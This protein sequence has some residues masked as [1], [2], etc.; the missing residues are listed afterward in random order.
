MLL[1]YTSIFDFIS[2]IKV[3][4][5]FCRVFL[6]LTYLNCAPSQPGLGKYITVFV[7]LLPF[8]CFYF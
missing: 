5:D 2:P 6:Y 8:S 3:L 1:L 7:V 4:R